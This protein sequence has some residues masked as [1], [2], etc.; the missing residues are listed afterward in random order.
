MEVVQN[1]GHTDVDTTEDAL[2]EALQGGPV[3]VAV[4]A[5]T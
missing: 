5:N 3:S 2:V 1:K 4:A